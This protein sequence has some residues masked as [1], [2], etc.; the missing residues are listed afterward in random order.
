MSSS[1]ASPS[2]GI[3]ATPGGA[4]H[5][6]R[7]APLR[8]PAGQP[9]PPGSRFACLTTHR[10]SHVAAF[11]SFHACQRHYPGG[12]KG[13]PASLAFRPPSPFLR[14]VGPRIAR[15]GIAFRPACS[16]KTPGCFS[17]ASSPC[18]QPERH[19]Q[20][21]PFHTEKCG[22]ARETGGLIRRAPTAAGLPLPSESAGAEAGVA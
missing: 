15:F 11:F 14:W 2:G 22:L 5:L 13:V 20:R 3:R 12:S 18:Y 16:L 4:P 1:D 6:N 21:T 17:I 19:R 8:H 10:A 9:P 7:R